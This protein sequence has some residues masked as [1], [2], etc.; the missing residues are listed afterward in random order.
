[1]EAY[2]INPV[3]RKAGAVSRSKK[4]AKG[5]RNKKGQF[6]KK[7]AKSATKV[8]KVRK[9]RKARKAST[10]KKTKTR[11]TQ[12][13]GVKG[14]TVKKHSVRKHKAHGR[15]TSWLSNP[16]ILGEVTHGLIT[17]GVL[18][19]ALFAVGFVGK[20]VE[21]LPIPQGK[22]TPL[23]TKLGVALLAVWGVRQ[24]AR[25]GILKGEQVIVA[26]TAAFVP[27]GMSLL[28]TFAPQA[29]AQV[30]LAAEMNAE[31]NGYLPQDLG[32]AMSPRGRLSDY[33]VSAELNAELESESES[34]S[35]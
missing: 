25:R 7:G 19:G 2:L 18:F 21:K 23:L 13:W 20:Q 8:R 14:Y 35:F 31:L 12:V 4:M 6:V 9:V 15:T 3:S 27:L 34:G 11:K 26:Q 1:M 28:S 24:L 17:A 16:P 5:K 33:T 29:A 32:M 30:S 22:Y 10:G